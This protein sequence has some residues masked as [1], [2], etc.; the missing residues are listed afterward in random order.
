[1]ILEKS[2]Y[3]AMGAAFIQ[4]ISD[5]IELIIS[6]DAQITLIVQDRDDPNVSDWFYLGHGRKTLVGLQAAIETLLTKLH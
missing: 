3:K 6:Q 5:H 1:M 4:P 2:D